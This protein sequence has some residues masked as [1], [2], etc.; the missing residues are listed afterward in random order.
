MNGPDSRQEI[1]PPHEPGK[2]ERLQSGFDRG[3]KVSRDMSVHYGERAGHLFGEYGVRM[4][5]LMHRCMQWCEQIEMV[6]RWVDRGGWM[7][8]VPYAVGVLLFLTGWFMSAEDLRMLWLVLSG[9]LAV[10]GF[11]VLVLVNLII[12]DRAEEKRSAESD[13]QDSMQA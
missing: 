12:R 8:F 11:V 4:G 1:N 7:L 3:F 6:N 5:R 13:D 10:V 2:F 9:V